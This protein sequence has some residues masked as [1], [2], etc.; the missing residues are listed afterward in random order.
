MLNRFMLIVIVVPLAIILVALAV[1]NR[2]P[3]AFTMDPFNPGNPALTL[4]TAAVRAAVPGAGVGMV[5][6]S[7]ATWL[8]RA[9]TASWRAS[10]ARRPRRC[11]RRSVRADATAPA[12]PR[13]NSGRPPETG[14]TPPFS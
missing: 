13:Q 12:L 8:D 3:A 11:G 2:E 14:A 9:A 6:G 10:A 4:E 1:A 7:F 5:V